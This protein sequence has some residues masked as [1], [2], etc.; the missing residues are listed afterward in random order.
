GEGC[1]INLASMYGV[2]AAPD[3]AAYCA[4]KGAVGLLT[5]TLAVEWGPQGGRVNRRP[6]GD[7]ETELVRDRP[8]RGRRD[9][10]RLDQRPPWRRMA[11][12]A[13]MA[14]LA[15]FLASRQAAYIT[16]HTL[17]ADGGWSRY[18]YL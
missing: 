8:A 7:G 13:E 1:I 9:P 3:R 10:D 2:V 14:D 5:E 6:P 4:T 18:S 12:P 17:V 15:V 16:G 11:Q